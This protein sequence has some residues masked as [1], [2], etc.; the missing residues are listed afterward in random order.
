MVIRQLVGNGHPAVSRSR[1]S[2]KLVGHNQISTYVIRYVKS[3]VIS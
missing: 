2:G 1:P 3:D